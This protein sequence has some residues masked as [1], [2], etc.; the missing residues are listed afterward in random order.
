MTSQSLIEALVVILKVKMT[1]IW[2][3]SKWENTL[4]NTAIKQNSSQNK[5]QLVSLCILLK[6]LKIIMQMKLK[7]W[8]WMSKQKKKNSSSN[9]KWLENQTLLQ[10]GLL[11]WLF[12]CLNMMKA[13]FVW[14]LQK[15]PDVHLPFTIRFK[16]SNKNFLR[17]YIN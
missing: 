17:L 16:S 8:I 11:K 10:I 4:S 15:C 13:L 5:I 12:S 2:I 1:C 3:I 9:S 6:C 7:V 14:D